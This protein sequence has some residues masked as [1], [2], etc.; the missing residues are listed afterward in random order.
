MVALHPQLTYIGAS[1]NNDNA[2]ILFTAL[3]AYLMVSLLFGGGGRSTLVA[4]VL[5]IAGS[6]MTK[7]QVLPITIVS[8]LTVLGYLVWWAAVQRSREPLLYIGLGALALVPVLARGG[9]AL[10][11]RAQTMASVL[12]NWQESASTAIRMGLDPLSYQFF[13]FWAAFAGE[14]VRPPALSYAGP[15]A[16]ISLALVGYV[17]HL[18]RRID[19]GKLPSPGP[20]LSRGVLALMV[21]GVWILVYLMYLRFNNPSYQYVGWSLPAISGRYLLTAIVPLALLIAEGWSLLVPKLHH[22]SFVLLVAV[23][24]TL[25]DI[26]SLA[27][28]AG[29]YRWPI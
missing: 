17:V 2:A 16:A 28:L 18:Y 6:L 12:E 9:E 25:F 22:R 11:T 10:I 21:A 23:V 20:I 24:F 3:L 7:G 19:P 13:T 26:F 15:A 14:A 8:A 1:A 4:A 27:A 29:L 5:A